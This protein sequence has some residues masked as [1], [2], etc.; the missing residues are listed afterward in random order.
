MQLPGG[1]QENF[2]FLVLE[3]C[4][5]VEETLAFLQA[6]SQRQMERITGR[7]DYID[8]LKS[9]IEEKVYSLLMSTVMERRQANLLRSVNTIATNLERI[10]DFA[11][12]VV[13]QMQYLTDPAFVNA[14]DHPPYF[15]EVKEGLDTILEAFTSQDISLAFRICQ[16]EFHLDDLYKGTMNRLLQEL[17]QGR[18]T[19]DL[20][21]VLFIFR[22]LERM[23]DSLLNIGEAIIFALLGE[24]LKIHQ[25]QA[26]RDSLA[27]SGMNTP[28]SEVEFESIWGTRS[29]C[30]IGKVQDKAGGE[31]AQRVIFKEG[32]ANKLASE[33]D[34]IARWES[35][36][37]GLAPKVFGF[38]RDN[39]SASILL[40]YLEGCT[41]QELILNSETEYQENALFLVTETLKMIWQNTRKDRASDGNFLAQ[42]LSRL[43]DVYRVHPHFKQSCQSI[44]DLALAPLEESLRQLQ[45]KTQGRLLAPF[46]V[47][48]HGDFNANNVI[49]DHNQ[50]RVHFIDLHRSADS[51][52]AQDISVFLVSNF[53]MP[54][55][56][57]VLRTRL[58]RV[59]LDFLLF[60]QNF[61]REQGDATFEARLCLGLIRSF[62]TSTRFELNLDFAKEMFLR[63]CYLLDK[64]NNHGGRPWEDFRLP[65]HV[66]VY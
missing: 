11:V 15:K 9:L 7:D 48:I 25:Y 54:V 6:P 63:S 64:M 44:G 34:N 23:G 4:K 42:L 24:R 31:S 10:A 47:F 30:R 39:G 65:P 56:R 17:A 19:G 20:V 8:G 28:I 38:Q 40:E 61:A 36:M 51:D 35:I 22:Y 62:L 53:R 50:Q 55:Q 1:L 60:A 27:N 21:T 12:N 59:I 32:N 29:G 45:E 5:Q 58:N 57:S 3:V 52:Y 18:N 37:P 33:R 14:Y 43:D 66:L 49:Y 46:S 2:R 13:G 16:S 41:L 26:L